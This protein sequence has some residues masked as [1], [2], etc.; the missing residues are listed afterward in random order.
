MKIGR[1]IGV[2][3]GIGLVGLLLGGL[4]RIYLAFSLTSPIAF[5]NDATEVFD[6]AGRCG[7]PTVLFW[8]SVAAIFLVLCGSIVWQLLRHK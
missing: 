6:S 5:C 8:I 1:L 2:L 3:L 4:V 7:N